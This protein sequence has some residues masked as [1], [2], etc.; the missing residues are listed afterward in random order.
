ML[1]V[2]GLGDGVGAIE[3]EGDDLLERK[4]ADVDGAMDAVARLDPIHFADRD[5]PRDCFTAV[6]EFNVEQI[7]AEDDR[8]AMVGIVVP[9]CRFAGREALAADEEISAMV[10]DLLI[11]G[12]IHFSILR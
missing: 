12:E 4:L 7:A 9:G 10:K 8:D 3:E 6:A 1:S 5:V 11:F 2:F